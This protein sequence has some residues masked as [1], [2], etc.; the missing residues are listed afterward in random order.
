MKKTRSRKS[1]DTVPLIAFHWFFCLRKEK[2]WCW[3]HMGRR[4]VGLLR[5]K[6]RTVERGCTSGKSEPADYPS[7]CIFQM[8]FT[9]LKVSGNWFIKT[10]LT[11]QISWHCHFNNFLWQVGTK[12]TDLGV[13]F[14]SYTAE[15]YNNLSRPRVRLNR[16]FCYWVILPEWIWKWSLRI[17]RIR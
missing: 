13:S 16:Q 15:R 6:D 17:W 8:A 14:I 11:S 3:I 1:R 4:S 2:T 7:W 10:N 9:V 5:Y 12:M